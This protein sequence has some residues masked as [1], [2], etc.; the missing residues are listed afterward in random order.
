MSRLWWRCSALLLWLVGLLVVCCAWCLLVGLLAVQ[1]WWLLLAELWVL[2]E[3]LA[4]C[5]FSLLFLPLLSVL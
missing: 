1:L 2:P 5:Q 4:E 3:L